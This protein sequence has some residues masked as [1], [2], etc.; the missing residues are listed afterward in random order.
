MKEEILQQMPQK[1]KRILGVYYE[2]LYTNNLHNLE[3]INK[4]LE[5]CS[6]TK[7]NREEI[8]GL[9][10]PITNKENESVIKTSEQRKA[11]VQMASHVNSTE[12]SKNYHQSF[13]DS[14]KKQKMRE[15]FQTNL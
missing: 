2:L 10:R 15:H 7:L 6:T 5:T 1:Q 14:F 13:L 4:F 3:K 12:Q 8:E 9:N 11:Q